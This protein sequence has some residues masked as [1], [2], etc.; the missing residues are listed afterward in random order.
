MAWAISKRFFSIEFFDCCE[1][2]IKPLTT[3]HLFKSPVSPVFHTVVTASSGLKNMFRV[4]T[5]IQK[6]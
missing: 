2:S 6:Y 3:F 4:G 1:Q 5:S